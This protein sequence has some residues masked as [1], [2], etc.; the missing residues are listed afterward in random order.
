[1]RWTSTPS[2]GAVTW[3]VRSWPAPRP[4]RGERPQTYV[5]KHHPKPSEARNAAH[6]APTD[7][8]YEIVRRY[9]NIRGWNG[10]GKR[11]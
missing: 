7:K 6:L 9:M 5:R 11:K 10:S 8:F 4:G 3:A 1:M 2:T